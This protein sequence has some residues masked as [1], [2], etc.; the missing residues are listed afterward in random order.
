MNEVRLIDADA[1]KTEFLRKIGGDFADI[2]DNA[3]TVGAYTEKQVK[4]LIEL[5]EKQIKEL[6]ELNEELSEERPKGE[7][8]TETSGYYSYFRCNNCNSYCSSVKTNFCPNCGASMSRG[9]KE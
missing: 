2:I 6:I 4:E 8:I 3:P 1:L 9:D 5:N 7:W